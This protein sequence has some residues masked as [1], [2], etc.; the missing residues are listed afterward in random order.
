MLLLLPCLL[1]PHLRLLLLH[2]LAADPAAA[3]A[4]PLCQP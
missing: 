4:C 1:E 2:L 3:A